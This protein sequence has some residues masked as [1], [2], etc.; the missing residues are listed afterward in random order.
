MANDWKDNAFP[1][2]EN[3]VNKTGNVIGGDVLLKCVADGNITIKYKNNPTSKVVACVV[4]DAYRTVEAETVT[5]TSGTYH[6]G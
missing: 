2:S 6:I 4:G 3:G 1:L 5:L